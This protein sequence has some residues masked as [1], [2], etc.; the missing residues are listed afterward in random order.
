MKKFVLLTSAV[1]LAL[2]GLGTTN[3]QA[4][5]ANTNN[6]PVTFQITAAI[7]KTSVITNG[8]LVTAT[9]S[10][11]SLKINNK[12]I[13]NLLEVEFG[14]NFP[15]GAQLAFS[16]ASIN[17]FSVLDRNGGLILDVSTNAADASYIFSLS[18]NVINATSSVPILITGKGTQNIV[19][20]N[21]I[22][23]IT[24]FAPD[25]GVFYRDAHGNDFHM[26][27]VLTV[28]AKISTTSSNTTHDTLSFTLVG[29]GGG[30]FFNSNTSTIVTGTFTKAKFSAKGT[31]LI[32]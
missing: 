20:S 2:L 27:G 32:E 30:T 28:K 22:D 26:D 5:P 17:G 29:A 4:M 25:T 19:T 7:Q 1:T 8:T 15:A 13:L 11:T 9:E 18:N 10:A 3:L 24:E 6:L 16:L 21:F 12:F 14:T 31:S 23:N